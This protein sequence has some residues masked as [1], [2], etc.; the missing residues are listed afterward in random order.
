MS[1]QPI[2]IWAM[3]VCLMFCSYLI[4][5]QSKEKAY[6]ETIDAL[7]AAGFLKTKKVNGEIEIL[8]WN[9]K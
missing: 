6:A 2:E 8:K 9:E 7:I 3:I 5:K 4:G 1:G